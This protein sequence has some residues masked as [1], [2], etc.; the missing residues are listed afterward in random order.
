MSGSV[1]LASSRLAEDIADLSGA[2]GYPR[3]DGH[4]RAVDGGSQG[5]HRQGERNFE[6]EAQA[7]VCWRRGRF[8]HSENGPIPWLWPFRV[9]MRAARR[10]GLQKE[11]ASVRALAEGGWPTQF[12][13]H[14]HRRA[15]H[16][17]CAC[18]AAVGTLRHKLGGCSLAEDLRRRECPEWLLKCCG[19]GGW[20]PLFTRGVPARPKAPRIPKNLVWAE[21]ADGDQVHYATGDLYTDGSAKGM[22]WGARRGG[23]AV[24]ALD[25]HG[26]W[27]WT[28][29]GTLGG[30]N[31]SSFRAELQALLEALKMA[32]PPVRIHTDNQNVVDGVLR[33]KLWSTRAKAAGAD[34][35]RSVFDKLEELKDQGEVS[36]VKVKAHTSWWD[37]LS[38]RITPKEQFGN[39]LADT[40]AK[41]AT[42]ASEA[43]APTAGFN[44]QVKTALAWV[45]WAARYSTDWV[46][47]IAP[48]QMPAV[49]PPTERAW[50]YGDTHLRHEKWSV[51]QRALCRRCGI[52]MP[53]NEGAAR[54]SLQC[55]GS[56]AGRAAARATGNI[57]Y[58][59][60]RFLH[61]RR[62]LIERGGAQVCTAP[63]PRWIVDPQ[64]LEEVISSR[65]QT[66]HV[67]ER[68]DSGQQGTLANQPVPFWM[69]APEWMPFHL[70]QPWERGE[71]QPKK[72]SGCR[73]EELEARSGEHKV[74]FA[75]SIV[76]CLRCACFAQRRLGSRF[77]GACALPVGRAAA[78]VA[79]RLARL[80]SG[81]HP[82]S[83]RALS[84]EIFLT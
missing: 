69:R 25:A 2:H 21:S 44:D 73:R 9:V 32:V 51:G 40:A 28:R 6:K 22:F 8:E 84:E 75:G 20:D 59:W 36:V 52:A 15:E 66:Q 23:W 13:L 56:A 74:A 35:W 48:C 3:D 31:V 55:A 45:R 62:E 79:Y 78:A 43:D 34:L 46:K 30:P 68:R 50:E 29:R 67:A 7:A 54:V 11:A 38:N 65:L 18:G 19:R 81:R 41:A 16:M 14:C 37:L 42:A 33:G 76:F 53:A 27:L 82:L 24:V 39:W 10:H 1:A 71:G 61:S 63:P 70:F 57:N 17:D 26:R 58:V 72:P 60:A 47:D 49:S 64:R 80:K 4:A 12:R 83:G 5:P 77:K